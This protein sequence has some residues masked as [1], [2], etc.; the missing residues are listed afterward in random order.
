LERDRRNSGA[1]PMIDEPVVRDGVEPCGEPRRGLVVDARLDHAH[2]DLLVDFLRDG[3]HLYVAQDEAKE[4][5]AVARI[6]LLEGRR[7]S[8]AIREHELFVRG[9]PHS[10]RV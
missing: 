5:C 4:A 10:W 9:L 6:E 3:T 7:I 1:P 8:A 2:P